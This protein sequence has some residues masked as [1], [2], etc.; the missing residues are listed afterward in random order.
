MDEARKVGLDC[1]ILNPNHYVPLESL[2]AS[3][4]ELARK[5]IL[6]R[7][8]VAFEELEQIA[9]TKKTGTQVKKIDYDDLSLEESICQKI[10]DGFKQKQEGVIEKEGG[11]FPYK[12]QIVVDVAKVI[13]KHEPLSFVSGYLMKS[14]RELGDAFGRGEVS[15]PHLLKSADVMRHVMQFLESFMR[16]ESGIEPG[17]AIDYKGVVVIGTVYQDVHSI[18]K[19]LAKTLLENYGY[20]VIDLGVQVPLSLIH[21]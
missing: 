4:V 2:T 3:D 13:E 16:F 18:G 6:D 8:M 10:K 12:D 20:R 1:A 15:L 17:A 7:D 9:Q 14:M 19:D 21:I 5:V 11:K